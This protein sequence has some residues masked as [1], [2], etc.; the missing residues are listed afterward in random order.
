MARYRMAVG[1]AL[2]I[3]G[4]YL[5]LVTFVMVRSSYDTWVAFFLAPGLFLLCAPLLRRSLAKHEPD[6]WVRKAVVAGLGVKLAFGFIRFYANSLV[7]GHGDAK[8]Y[9]LAGA[10]VS[11]EFRSFI[12]GGPAFQRWITDYTST[13]FIRLV[14]AL[15]YVVTGPTQLGVR[16]VLL[17]VVLG[18]VPLL[19]GVLH[20]TS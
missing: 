5:I 4:A 17:H 11:A 6:Q 20:R 7:L 16:D 12:F 15:V 8:N 14:V 2:L 19:P 18:A 10:E 13:R 1:A 9:F 3:V